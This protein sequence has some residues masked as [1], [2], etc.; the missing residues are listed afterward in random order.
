MASEHQHW[1]E[2]S[3]ASLVLRVCMDYCDWRTAP[4]SMAHATHQIAMDLMAYE[5]A[6]TAME[7]ERHG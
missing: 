5:T 2:T 3:S 1:L 7:R 4:E 6:P